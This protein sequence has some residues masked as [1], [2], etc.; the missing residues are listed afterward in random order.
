MLDLL[1]ASFYGDLHVDKIAVVPVP[2]V[3]VALCTLAT[4]QNHLISADN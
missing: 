1:M 3:V 4:G 2:F